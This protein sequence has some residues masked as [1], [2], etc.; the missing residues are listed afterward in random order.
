MKRLAIGVFVFFCLGSLYINTTQ[1][2]DNPEAFRVNLKR[3]DNQKNSVGSGFSFDEKEVADIVQKYPV[4]LPQPMPAEAKLGYFYGGPIYAIL[5]KTPGQPK[6]RLTMDVNANFDLTDDPVLELAQS[7]KMEEWTVVKIA[8]PF[9]GTSPRTEWLPYRIGYREYKGRDGKIQ[10]SINIGAE[11]AFQ[12]DFRLGNHDY[13]LQLMDGDARGRFIR[14]KLVNVYI[15]IKMKGDMM[16]GQGHRFFE[17][18]PIE[19]SLYEVKDFAEDG[20]WIDFIKSPLPPAALGKA[21]PDMEL[22]DTTGRKFRLS[23]YKDKLLLLDF[24]PSWCKPC[25]AEFAEIKKILQQYEGRSLAVIGVNID[26]APRLEQARKVIAE[27]NLPWPQIMDGKGEFIPVYQVYGRLPEH[28]NSFPAYVAIDRQGIARYATN[29]FNKMARFLAAKLAPENASTETLFVPLLEMKTLLAPPAGVD[30][31]RSNVEEFLRI[32]PVKIPKD[33]PA[34]ARVGLTSNGTLVIASPG[35]TPDTVRL[36]VDSE[37]DFDLLNDKA[38]EIPI[39]RKPNVGKSDAKGIQI[40]ITYESG[41]RSFISFPFFAKTA[42]DGKIPDIFVFGFQQVFS[43]AFFEGNEEYQIE[44]TDPTPDRL[45]SKED[46]TRPDILKLSQKK[47]GQ[48]I[49]VYK[50]SEKIPIGGRLFR[51]RFISDDGYLIELE[52]EK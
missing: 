3:I 37:R 13:G 40:I 8:R 27:Y 38:Q 23:D 11:Y 41:A 15:S 42:Q 45:F 47:D 9:G 19:G 5:Q 31:S 51:L 21:A 16:P 20:S 48:W 35:S 26:E 33:L 4:K 46:M 12:G 30:F 25:V 39:V 6:I 10:D 7:D 43:G 32:H 28:A 50:G 18:I 36:I 17:L 34:D 29:D 44:L 52:K 1:T 49:E 24:W 2:A 22:T 14:E